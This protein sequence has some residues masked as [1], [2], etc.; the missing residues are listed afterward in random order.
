[1]LL[2]DLADAAMGV[3][4]ESRPRWQAPYDIAAAIENLRD[5]AA[6][7]LAERDEARAAACEAVYERIHKEQEMPNISKLPPAP[8]KA[9]TAERPD[10]RGECVRSDT[11]KIIPNLANAEIAIRGTPELADVL[12]FDQMAR[13]AMWREPA[14]VRPV[15][16]TD[17]RRIQKWLQLSGIPRISKDA[18]HDAVDI[19]AQDRGFHPLR[20]YLTGLEWDGKPR[21]SIWLTRYLGAELTLYTQAIG[22][23]F[24]ISMV[25]RILHPGCKADYMLVL[26]GPQGAMKSTACKALASE[27]YF[28]DNL[29]DVTNKDASSYLRGLWLIEIAEMHTATKADAAALKAYLTR[30]VERYRP[31]YGR[32]EVIEPRQCVY[33]GTTNRQVYLKDETGGRRFWPVA[34][35]HIDIEALKRDRDQLFAEAVVRYRAGEHWWPDKDFEREHI[36]PEQAE[37]YDADAWEDVVAKYLADRKATEVVT[38]GSVALCALRIEG[39]QLGRAEQNRIVAI[40]ERLGWKRGKRSDAKG[41]RRWVLPGR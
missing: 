11:G 38:V 15:T 21:L 9:L 30:R 7:R 16:D 39:K 5:I 17:I 19:V 2:I 25:A 24:L 1:M 20:N 35:G 27:R 40:M 31:S 6:E 3:P 41:T 22:R 34:C 8:T 32:L 12:A 10:W 14:E 4:G 36:I 29:P 18:V 23:M 37:R 33:I 26:E 28:D 13:V